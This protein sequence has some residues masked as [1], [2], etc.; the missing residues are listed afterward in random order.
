[1]GLTVAFARDFAKHA[2]LVLFH[3]MRV[4]AAG[5]RASLQLVDAWGVEKGCVSPKCAF[6][7]ARA[8]GHGSGKGTR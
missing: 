4:I 7:M 3:L 8:D 2:P 5:D 1:M 6:G